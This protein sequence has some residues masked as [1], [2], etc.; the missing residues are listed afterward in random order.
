MGQAVAKIDTDLAETSCMNPEIRE[1]IG[2]ARAYQV[3]KKDPSVFE[4]EIKALERLARITWPRK[5]ITDLA[6]RMGIDT[7]D[8]GYGE[9]ES[10]DANDTE[11]EADI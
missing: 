5:E 8:I 9:G 1:L 6:L 7:V 11:K 2:Y 4:D 10:E 3:Y